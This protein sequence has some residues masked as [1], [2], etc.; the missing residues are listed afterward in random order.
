MSFWRPPPT[1]FDISLLELFLPLVSGARLVLADTR[2][3]LDP[4]AMDGL[5]QRWGV[6]L[7]QATPS[8]W[9]SLVH[10]GWRGGPHVRVIIGGE[11]LSADLAL[12]VL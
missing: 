9:W 5:L 2:Q 7:A 8:A 3:L 4:A 10:G 12:A 11:A 1:P 6:T